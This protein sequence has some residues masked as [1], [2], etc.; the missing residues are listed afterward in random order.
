MAAKKKSTGSLPFR[1][2]VMDYH[3]FEY[4]QDLLR[5]VNPEIKVFE[6]GC[7]PAV[8]LQVHHRVYHGIAYVGLKSDTKV[9]ALIAEIKEEQNESDNRIL[10]Y[11]RQ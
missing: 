11:C 9:K 1:V 4:I 5:K 10:E 8:E 7:A 3:E 6:A 2:E